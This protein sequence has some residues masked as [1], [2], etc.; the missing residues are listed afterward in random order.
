M[1]QSQNLLDGFNLGIVANLFDGSG[2]DIKRFALERKHAV[3]VAPDFTRYREDNSV[4]GRYF[5]L[6]VVTRVDGH[7]GIQIGSGNGS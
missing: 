1:F 6:Y 2:A 3:F 4:I 5:S 7:W